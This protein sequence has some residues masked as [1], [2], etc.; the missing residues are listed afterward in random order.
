MLAGSAEFMKIIDLS[1]STWQLR[2]WRPEIWRLNTSM[3]LGESLRAEIPPMP[4]RVP[5]SAQAALR[6]NGLLPDWNIGLNSL[7]CE[8]VENRHWEFFTTLTMPAD[9]QRVILEAEML[10]YS[11]WILVD[12]KAAKEFTGTLL[13]QSLDL[14]EHLRPGQT[15][16]LAI[17]FATA[18][19]EQGQI[20]FTS[21][22]RH[23]KPRFSYSWDWC[24]RFVPVGIGRSIVLRFDP[25]ALA[26]ESVQTGVSD[27]LQAGW[28]EI[29]HQASRPSAGMI[30]MTAPDGKSLTHAVSFPEGRGSQRIAIEHPA[31]WWPN[32]QGSQALYQAEVLTEAGEHCWLGEVGFKKVRWLPCEGAPDTAEP[33][34]CEINGRKIF[35]QG[36]NWTPAAL[37]YLSE[38]AEDVAKLISLYR[39][40]GCNFLRVWGGAY[41][42]STNFYKLADAAG[43]MVW[44]EFPLSSSGIENWPPEDPEVIDQLEIIA[45]DFVRHRA[46]H[47]SVILWCGGNELQSDENSKSGCGRPCDISHPCL[48]RLGEVVARETPGVRYVP[49]SSSGPR[50]SAEEKDFGKGLHHDVHGPWKL[51]GSMADWRRYWK[52]VDALFYSEVGSPGGGYSK[53]FRKRTLLRRTWKP[54]ARGAALYRPRRWR[55]WPNPAGIVSRAAAGCCSGWDTIVSLAPETRRSLTS[56][57]TPNLPMTPCAKFFNC[58]WPA[59]SEVNVRAWPDRATPCNHR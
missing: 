6:A 3:E 34:I 42:E 38:S 11:G 21:R 10:D 36:V 45:T 18:P 32:G 1:H 51:P 13:H 20:G 5:G 44:Q 53:N 8:W 19:D 59:S 27:D 26:V 33:W 46:H 48:R 22:S 24:P 30:R 28:L 17:L 14:T 47:A 12:G 16:R 50:F 54:T 31:L 29:R 7:Q 49:T 9:F 57:A 37:D 39:E 15:H 35:L 4:A 52:N 55:S 43:L 2:G 23:F 40:M 56:S 58:L 25:P 41:L